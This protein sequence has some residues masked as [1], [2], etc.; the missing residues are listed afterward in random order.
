[1]HRAKQ[2]RAAQC[3][4][5]GARPAAGSEPRVPPPSRW[6]GW[7]RPLHLPRRPHLPHGCLE[8]CGRM[9]AAV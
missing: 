3:I 5:G 1:M 4:G 7:G 9:L 8:G 6:A 2:V